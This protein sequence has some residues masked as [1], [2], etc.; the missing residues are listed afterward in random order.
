MNNGKRKNACPLN[1]AAA[2]GDCFWGNVGPLFLNYLIFLKVR[3]SGSVCEIS[4][5]LNVGAH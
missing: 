5:I 1:E 3:E 4:Q 2:P